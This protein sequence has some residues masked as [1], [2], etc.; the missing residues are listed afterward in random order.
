MEANHSSYYLKNGRN[1]PLLVALNYGVAF[2]NGQLIGMTRQDQQTEGL[3]EDRLTAVL[4]DED[5]V[6]PADTATTGIR[7]GRYLHF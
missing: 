2:R 5:Y 6:G 7:N 4:D 3:N 1:W